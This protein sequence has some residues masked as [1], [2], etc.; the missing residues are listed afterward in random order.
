M[1]KLW[2][3]IIEDVMPQFEEI[4]TDDCYCQHDRTVNHPTCEENIQ[5]DKFQAMSM[6]FQTTRLLSLKFLDA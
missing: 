5:I 1:E 2:R 6:W 3:Y 4:D